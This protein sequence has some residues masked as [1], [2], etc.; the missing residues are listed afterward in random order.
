MSRVSTLC[1]ACHRGS[2]R[3]CQPLHSCNGC[4][5]LQCLTVVPGSRLAQLQSGEI[6]QFA[7]DEM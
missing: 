3:A 7:I 4:P 5:R 1:R 2:G 6:E